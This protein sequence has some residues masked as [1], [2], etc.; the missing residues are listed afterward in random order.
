M[1]AIKKPFDLR[2][3]V[4]VKLSTEKETLKNQIG[5]YDEQF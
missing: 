1:L 3:D 2:G 5:D 4:I